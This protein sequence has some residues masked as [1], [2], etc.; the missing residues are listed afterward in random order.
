MAFK[1]L[2]DKVYDHTSGEEEKEPH[3]WQALGEQDFRANKFDDLLCRQEE[4]WEAL[5]V[6][7]TQQAAELEQLSMEVARGRWV[8]R[9]GLSVTTMSSEPGSVYGNEEGREVFSE[10]LVGAVGSG[11]V[12][13]PPDVQVAEEV[14]VP[15]EVEVET[16]VNPLPSYPAEYEM[17]Y[18]TQEL[19]QTQADIE[20]CEREA[21]EVGHISTHLSENR[22]S[23][24]H[25]HSKTFALPP[26]LGKLLN[27]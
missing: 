9:G 22:Q 10:Y 16:R 2:S 12:L 25:A 3:L 5:E 15:R 23:A 6:H 18:S 26:D 14:V 13:T 11:S 1:F 19:E 24:T 7:V 21:V 20:E 27:C 8:H 17:M 4:K